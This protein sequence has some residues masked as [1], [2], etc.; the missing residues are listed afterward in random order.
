MLDRTTRS[1]TSRVS[2]RT[3]PSPVVIVVTSPH[4]STGK[5][6][7]AINIALELAA[8]KARVLLIDGD[9]QGPAVANHFVLT[10]QP[11][12]LQA[13]LRIASQQRFDLEQLERLSFQFQ[14]STLRIMPGSQNFPS[15]PVDQGAVANLLETARSGYEFTVVDLGSLSGDGG[16]TQAELTNTIISL[17]DRKIVVCL[18]DPIGIFRLL[19]T[20]NLIAATSQPVDLV[21]NRVRNSVIASARREIAITL[22]RLSALEPK[23]YLPDDPQ[24]IDQAVRTGVPVTSL[25]RTGTFRQALTGFVRADLL[26]RK[27]ALDS[28]VAKLG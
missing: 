17:A 28:R 23:A 10:Q 5:T 16:G 27:G 12:G 13:A 25:S 24:H 22:Q 4:G 9:I 3:N 18:A 11:A 20:E 15:Q 26:G 8:E 14:K 7:V 1:I 19:G 2:P 6:T 21:M